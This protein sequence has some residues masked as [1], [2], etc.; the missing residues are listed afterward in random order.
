MTYLQHND[1]T[2]RRLVGSEVS[3]CEIDVVGFVGRIKLV[4]YYNAN[5]YLYD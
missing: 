1:F 5:I 3:K 2:I 4:G